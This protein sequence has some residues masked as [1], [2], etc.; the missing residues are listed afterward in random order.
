[1][2]NFVATFGYLCCIYRANGMKGK[3]YKF[4]FNDNGCNLIDI[5]LFQK[6]SEFS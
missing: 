5:E 1:M 6:I 2:E 3:F 4:S